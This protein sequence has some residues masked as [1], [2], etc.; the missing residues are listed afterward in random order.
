MSLAV[1][2]VLTL[3]VL[4][5]LLV[6]YATATTGP[7]V[8]FAPS[9]VM[10]QP[11]ET[12][13]FSVRVG[14]CEDSISGFQLYAR[15]DPA[16]VEYVSATQGSLY[17]YSGHPTW[18]IDPIEEEPGLWH[19]FDTVM[20]VGTYVSPPGELMRLELRAI[21]YGICEL[22]M[23]SILLADV[24]RENLPVGSYENADIFVIDPT[25]VEEGGG[26]VRLGPAYPN[27]FVAGTAVPFFAPRGPDDAV[28]EIYDVSGRLVRRLPVTDG[29]VDG[30][31][32]WDGRDEGGH[33]V[34][35][36]VYFLRVQAGT[37]TARCRLVKVE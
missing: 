5:T 10:L 20:G 37:S 11:G 23:E 12:V 15:F 29:V 30:E 28:A 22:Q 31:L 25:G 2:P 32:T 24:N 21:A 36:S 4:V 7:H 17:A 19:F 33:A 34:P 14:A 6:G 13:E 3:A 16:I 27:P 18:F 9:E 26:T 8:F 35:S 1:V